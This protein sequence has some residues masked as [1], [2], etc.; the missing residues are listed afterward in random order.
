MQAEDGPQQLPNFTDKLFSHGVMIFF[1]FPIS[2]SQKRNWR[3]ADLLQI[4]TPSSVVV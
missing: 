4:L 2:D 3:K 1:C